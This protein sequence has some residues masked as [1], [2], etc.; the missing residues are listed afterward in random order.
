VVVGCWDEDDAD[1]L[2]LGTFVPYSDPDVPVYRASEH[3]GRVDDYTDVPG[4]AA[5][6]T[7]EAGYLS[8]VVAPIV[9]GGR[10]W[11]AVFVFSTQPRHFASDSE[12]RLAGFAELVGLALE[13]VEAY[14]Q[15]SASRMRIVEAALSERAA[16]TATST[17]ARSSGSSHCHYSFGWRSGRCTT[18][19]TE[20]RRC[21]Q[22]PATSS[23][24][25]S[26]SSASSPVDSTPPS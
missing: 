2:Q 15:L 11:G 14:D 17:T 9:A 4:E 23:T 1:G 22:R 7:R 5:R 12:R 3:G 18:I 13:S 10:T 19:P 20:P 8:S 26:R 6:M 21:S 24:S 25:R 16:S